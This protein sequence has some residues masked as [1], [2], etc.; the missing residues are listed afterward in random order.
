MPEPRLLHI[1]RGYC[2]PVCSSNQYQG[3]AVSVR[4]P[5]AEN[6]DNY[7]L[8]QPGGKAEYLLNEQAESRRITGWGKQWWRLLV[9][10]GM[11]G[12][13]NG[14]EVS[15]ALVQLALAVRPVWDTSTL[16]HT[17]NA[18]HQQLQARF[19]QLHD[20]H[21]PG[22]TLVWADVHVS[23]LVM[24][25]HV[26]DSRLYHWQAVRQTWRQVTHDHTR[27]EFAWRTDAEAAG[28]SPAQE[29]GLAQAIGYGSYGVLPNTGGECLPAF[30][31]RIR[32]DLAEEMLP[33]A[34]THADVT[35]LSLQRGDALLLSTDGLWATPGQDTPALP[36]LAALD[37]PPSLDKLTRDILAAGGQDNTTAVL[38]KPKLPD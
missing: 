18:L 36:P 6:Q 8:V 28:R 30:S 13:R 1:L 4:G 10:D 27:Q 37:S 38:F 31:P 22:T 16:R 2:C 20:Q 29:K 5:R 21:S 32:L 17:L 33:H 24:L 7:L 11:G 34:H 12:H 9:A 15:E 23:G 19:G 26:G 14:R 35:R 3:M 25:A